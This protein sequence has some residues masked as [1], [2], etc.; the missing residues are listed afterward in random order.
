MLYR[1]VRSQV[2]CDGGRES[3]FQVGL[4]G[5]VYKEVG[6][7]SGSGDRGGCFQSQVVGDDA[8]GGLPL[9]LTP[10]SRGIVVLH[11]ISSSVKTFGALTILSGLQSA[12]PCLPTHPPFPPPRAT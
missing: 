8:R 2:R 4:G 9:S 11:P 1:W 10:I 12:G 7:D 6:C 3:P 5:Y